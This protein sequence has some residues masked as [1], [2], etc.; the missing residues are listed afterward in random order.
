MAE[1]VT[2]PYPGIFLPCKN[3][4]FCDDPGTPVTDGAKSGNYDMRGRG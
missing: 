3:H 1:G 4:V 2:A